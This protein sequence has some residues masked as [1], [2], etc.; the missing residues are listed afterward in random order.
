MQQLQNPIQ[1]NLLL[2]NLIESKSCNKDIKAAEARD[3]PETRTSTSVQID[4]KVEPEI[5]EIEKVNQMQHDIVVTHD[6]SRPSV[7]MA[8]PEPIV[9]NKN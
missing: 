9:H 1:L 3:Q 2:T 8:S 5:N 7:P 6:Y 4:Q